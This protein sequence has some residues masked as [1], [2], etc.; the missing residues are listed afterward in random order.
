MADWYPMATDV[1]ADERV[2]GLSPV[3]FRAWVMLRCV[4]SGAETGGVVLVPNPRRGPGA[5]ALH[6]RLERHATLVGVARIPHWRA[7]HEL[8]EAGLLVHC[9]DGSGGLAL[10]DRDEWMS[11]ETRMDAR[12]EANRARRATPVRV[13]AA[14]RTR[15]APSPHVDDAPPDR[16]VEREN[17]VNSLSTSSKANSRTARDAKP[18]GLRRVDLAPHLQQPDPDGLRPFVRQALRTARNIGDPRI[19]QDLASNG[20]L[21]PAEHDAITLALETRNP[22]PHHDTPPN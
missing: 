13:E 7:I 5:L 22:E 12:R 9:N 16:E 4:A 1:F 19:L 15:L 21:N 10:H 3:A 2:A 11:R 18:D 20:D 17:E 6:P 8:L 14:S